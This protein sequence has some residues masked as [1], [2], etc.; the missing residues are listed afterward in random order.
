[1][2]HCARVTGKG[3]PLSQLRVQPGGHHNTGMCPAFHLVS[4]RPLC[5]EHLIVGLPPWL[6]AVN[7]VFW[8]LGNLR[9]WFLCAAWGF[10][11]TA[12]KV[13]CTINKTT[14]LFKNAVGIPLYW[15]QMVQCKAVMILDIERTT[16]RTHS[17]PTHSMFTLIN[18]GMWS[19]FCNSCV[20]QWIFK[21]FEMCSIFSLKELKLVRLTCN[22][23][24]HF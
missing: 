1:M 21:S 3:A 17:N 7:V 6:V 20:N 11:F 12:C 19:I 4:L 9:S 14:L 24:R 5:P 22:V 2:S 15:S 18:E 23:L 10:S 8:P 16:F 13:M